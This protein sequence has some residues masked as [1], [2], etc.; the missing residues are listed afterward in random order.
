[1]PEVVALRRGP[2]DMLDRLDQV[3]RG[4]H[5]DHDLLAVDH[6]HLGLA[7][8]PQQERLGDTR[9]PVRPAAHAAVGAGLEGGCD[10]SAVSLR[11]QVSPA[12]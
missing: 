9:M 4:R 8:R 10:G 2:T 7:V 11:Y 3:G 6:A 1:M 5:L 12:S